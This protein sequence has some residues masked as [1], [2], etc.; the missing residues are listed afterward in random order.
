MKDQLTRFLNDY[1]TKME[2]A[3]LFWLPLSDKPGTDLFN[4]AVHYAVFPS[5]KR[6][7]PLFTLLAA[8]SV[9]GKPENALTI[10]CAIEYF[11]T[12]SLIFDDLPAMDNARER[13]GKQ[14]TH[15]VFGEDAA[16]LAALALLNQGYA[17][18]GQM[19]FPEDQK[20]RMHRLMYEV[21]TCIGSNGMIGGQMV[22]LGLRKNVNEQLRSVSYTKTTA[23]TR[24]MLTTGA[25]VGG[26]NDEQIEILA[27]FGEDLGEAYQMLDDIV[28]EFED[29][30]K[31]G[32]YPMGIDIHALWHAANEKLKKSQDNVVK[33]LG[34]DNAGL[35]IE[36]TEKIFRK[37]KKQAADHLVEEKWAYSTGSHDGT[38]L[39]PD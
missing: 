19:E 17:L 6:M 11:H 23:L 15:Q 2:D 8:K 24:L 33:D 13:R 4:K 32:L 39:G 36:L 25:I 16:M 31:T 27:A 20:N 3:L 5:G 30:A 21:T 7:R 22:D 29:H 35:L 9:G 37:F 1:G 28:D 34:N 10:A 14:A 18:A 12:C 38:V 26:A